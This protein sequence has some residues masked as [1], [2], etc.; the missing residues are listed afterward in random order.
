MAVK[1]GGC[2]GLFRKALVLDF[3]SPASEDGRRRRCGFAHRG[4]AR[5][6]RAKS[7]TL[8]H[9]NSFIKT[10]DAYF[11]KT[12][13]PAYEKLTG[14]KVSYELASVGSLQTRVTTIAET[15]SG[16]DLTL[17]F[18]NWPF[19]YDEKYRRRERHRRS[20]RQAAGR[21]V[22]A[23]EGSLVVNGKWK[24]VPVRQCR[25]A[26]EL[27]HGLV[28]GGRLREIPGHL[29]RAARSRHQAQ[30]QGPSVRL[31]ARPRLRRQPRLAL[32]AA[33]V[34][35]RAR[36]RARRQD[37][38]ARF[39]RDRARRRLR[40]QVLPADHAR[41]RA[42]LDRRQQQQGLAQRADLLHQQCREHP[43][44][45]QAR[46]PGH[47]QGHRSGDSTRKA[48]KAASIMLNCWS[49]SI[50]T[51]TPDH[52]AAKAFLRWLCEKPQLGAWYASADTLLSAVPARL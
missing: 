21:L 29:G 13:A 23:G 1:L 6:R 3:A 7:L 42:R 24:A 12:L 34:L 39:R 52:E 43:V 11:Q 10:F 9:E 31:R 36:G 46:F 30:G 25:P 38:G 16:A 18:F 49:H 8:I 47:R 27:A 45:G 20:G 44:G 2:D 41:G 33:V 4:A 32:S 50:F 48:R 17:N 14:I 26:D 37:G 51:H 35:W 28:Q 40:P 19:L 15:G 22:R 5:P